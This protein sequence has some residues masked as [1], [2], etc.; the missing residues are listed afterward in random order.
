M[1]RPKLIEPEERR[2]HEKQLRQDA[3]KFAREAE[4][5]VS[6]SLEGYSL[7]PADGD[8]A[9]ELGECGTR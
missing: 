8:A 6:Q 2:K 4:A 5:A 9:T 1:P 3:E 7:K